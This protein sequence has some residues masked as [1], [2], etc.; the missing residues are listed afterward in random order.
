MRIFFFGAAPASTPAPESAETNPLRVVI[1]FLFGMTQPVYPRRACIVGIHSHPDPADKSGL[2][3]L[4]L[5]RALGA[6]NSK[7]NGVQ[8]GIITYSYRGMPNLDDIIKATVQLGINSVELMSNTVEAFAGAP[9]PP[10][11]GPGG[12]AGG[13][14]PPAGP[15][16]GQRGAPQPGAPGLGQPTP[17]MIAAMRARMNSPEAQKAREDLRMWRLAASTDQF[18][19]VRKKFDDA[20]IDLHLLCFNMQDTMTDDEVEFAFQMAEALGVQGIT[21]STTVSMSKRIAPLADKHQM[22]V[23][24]HGHDQ[25]ADPNQFAT[26]ESYATAF[27]YSNYNGVNLDI[28]HFTASNYDAI[29]FIKE[30]HARI[31]S[32]HLKDRRKDHTPN[33]PWGQGDTPIKEV[34]QLL[35]KEKYPFPGNI[36][37]E[38][39]GESDVLTEIAKCLEYCRQALA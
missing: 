26:L 28:G 17:E 7:F 6:P 11:F 25:T 24:Y 30:H 32:L 12:G 1:H 3:A 36:E 9:A 31:T 15:G 5:A 18:K 21:T 19:P 29:A 2:A 39:R 38:Y 14:R 4:P 8:I 20:G 35:K 37:Y 13:A 23:G 16:G 27:T 34:L 10:R 22:L 33:V